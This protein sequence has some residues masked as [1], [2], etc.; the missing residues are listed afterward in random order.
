MQTTKPITVGVPVN[1]ARSMDQMN[2]RLE[3]LTNAM[4]DI[5]DKFSSAAGGSSFAGISLGGGGGGGT[6]LDGIPGIATD[7]KAFF[8]ELVGDIG[9]TI[10]AEA[11]SL[12]P[13]DEEEKKKKSGEDASD[14]AI[15]ASADKAGVAP[16]E[17]TDAAKTQKEEADDAVKAEE[18]RE[19]A[20]S[21][22]WAGI[23]GN[24]LKS[25]KTLGKIRKAFAIGGVVMDT[26]RG[27]AKAVASAPFPA[28]LPA[29]AFATVTGAAQ[30]AA[31]KGQAHDGI[32]N[33][34]STGTY[35]LEAGERVV[36]RRL[37]ADLSRFLASQQGIV[38]GQI[39]TATTNTSNTLSPNINLTIGAGASPDA[40]HGNRGAL[41]SMIREIFADYAMEAPFG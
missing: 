23:V 37:N 3:K 17:A 33:I 38:P 1:F 34:P 10:K 32:D 5:A 41:E 22:A 4:D 14:E 35:L 18:A 36:D 31:V 26:A 28:N 9:A 19:K 15:G 2:H 13:D 30:L 11:P 27:I 29:I 20:N 6:Y 40:V 16:A 12:F 21:K 39:S 8:S 7:Y 25:S 24:A